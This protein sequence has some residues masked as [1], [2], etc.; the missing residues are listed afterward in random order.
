MNFEDEPYVRL[1]VR[2]TKTWLRLGFEGQCV[3][4][5]LLRKL[6]KAGVLDG[7][8][9]LDSDVAL[10]TGVPETIVA[11]GMPRLVRWGVLQ[12]AGN[13]LIMPNYIQA[14]NAIRTD[15][16]RQRDMREKRLSQARLVTP[17]DALVTPRDETSREPTP[18]D[19]VSRDVTLYCP[20]LYSSDHSLSDQ[21]AHSEPSQTEPPTHIRIPEGWNA[22]EE[23]FAEAFAAGVTRAGLE[24][25]VQYWRGRKLGGEWFTPED[26]FRGKFA[27][28]KIREEKS[29]FAE[30]QAR[31]GSR[32]APAN[33]LDTTGAATVFRVTD[34]HRQYALGKGLDW[35][36]AA[37]EYR[38]GKACARLSTA[39]QER[40]FLNRLRCWAA[41]GTF[42]AD[43]S[44]PKPKKPP[45]RAG[46]QEAA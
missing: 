34:E 27:A 13:R 11:V 12:L 21:Q 4:M 26:F 5:F 24:E 8:D 9:D 37:K 6:D 45:G 46:S 39:E 25:A 2:D 38:R 1:Y 3:L 10:V 43:G 32:Q 35:D 16:A 41:T 44:L 14:Q 23:L 36:A 19:A 31:S 22:P 30:Q 7:M 15:K 42:I 18:D 17:R 20:D 29:R 33:E 40:D 28:I